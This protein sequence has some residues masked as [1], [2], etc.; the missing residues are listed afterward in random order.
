MMDFDNYFQAMK[1][2]FGVDKKTEL[3]HVNEYT[4]AVAVVLSAQTTDKHVNTVTP[5]LFAVADTPEKMMRLGESRL[6]GYIKSISFFNNKAQNI[7][8]MAEMLTG[9]TQVFVTRK[10]LTKTIQPLRSGAGNTEW[11]FPEKYHDR[12]VLMQLP[13]I[14]QKT[15]NV[16]SNVLWDAPNI[17]VDT[18]VF[19][20]SH[21][22]GWVGDKDNTPEKVERQLLAVLPVQY[23]N[24]CNHLMVMHG[25]Y[26]C[27]A[28]KPDCKSCP[29]SKL[30]V[31]KDKATV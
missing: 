19:R 22:F 4:M 27:K 16:V 29:V 25:R 3:Y 30:C 24:V 18:H 1:K 15:A 8:K 17:G 31:A 11:R 12:D 7:I 23:R 9:P 14:G 10:A 26:I 5:V 20:L 13:G 21:R 2:R 28:L 6:K